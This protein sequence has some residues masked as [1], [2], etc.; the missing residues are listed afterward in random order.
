MSYDNRIV[1]GPGDIVDAHFEGNSLVS[2]SIPS[3][4]V[5]A[6][7]IFGGNS[8]YLNSLFFGTVPSATSTTN[9][10][11]NIL[12]YISPNSGSIV[13]ATL[14][15]NIPIF[16]PATAPSISSAT[17]LTFLNAM[18]LGF[19]NRTGANAYLHVLLNNGALT[20]GNILIVAGGGQT[21]LLS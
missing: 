3:G 15:Y 4:S 12:V 20:G 13:G 17:S 18:G 16:V 21:A 7:N 19:R 9:N 1:R 14:L 2:T 10:T 5:S 11:N 8:F 6:F